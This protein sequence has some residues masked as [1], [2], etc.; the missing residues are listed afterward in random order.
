[1]LAEHELL[2]RYGTAMLRLFAAMEGEPSQHERR[3]NISLR[4]IAEG[5]PPAKLITLPGWDRINKTID[6]DW[7]SCELLTETT[8]ETKKGPAKQ[9]MK[10][11]AFGFGL[12]HPARVATLRKNALEDL[13][14]VLGTIRSFTLDHRSVLA[15][16]RDNCAICGRV[17]TD[18]LSRSRGIGP[19]C[20]QKAPWLVTYG[21]HSILEAEAI[22]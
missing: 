17:L 11:L 8:V 9:W 14:R 10:V 3:P 20:I 7:L 2:M 21:N 19:E 22:R 5:D 12:G 15:R 18:E 6:R 1:M 16:A 4:L 13:E